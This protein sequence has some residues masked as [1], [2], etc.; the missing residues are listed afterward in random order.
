MYCSQPAP[1]Y[2][3]VLYWSALQEE[4]SKFL[5][6]AIIT[7]GG[8]ISN[9]GRPVTF[10]RIQ[11]EKNFAFV[12]VRSAEEASN[13]IALDGIVFKDVPLKVSQ[14]V[15]CVDPMWPRQGSYLLQPGQEANGCS[16]YR[17]LLA[18]MPPSWGKCRAQLCWTAIVCSQPSPSFG[19]AALNAIFRMGS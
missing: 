17:G 11:R 5:G 19:A 6:N 9:M 12:E 13:A 7:T 14:L 4:L 1:L 15:T 10:I 2:C 18:C 3:A 8:A 16:C